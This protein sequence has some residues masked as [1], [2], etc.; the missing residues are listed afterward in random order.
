MSSASALMM[1]PL[2]ANV[3]NTGPTSAKPMACMCSDGKRARTG[4]FI[5][6]PGPR[7]DML[8]VRDT[9]VSNEA[10]MAVK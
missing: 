6:S 2:A 10:L 4:N 5:S 7:D 1:D 3:R 8:E 9:P